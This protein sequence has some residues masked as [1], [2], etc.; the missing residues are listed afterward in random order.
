MPMF[1]KFRVSGTDIDFERL[2]AAF[3]DEPSEI[4]TRGELFYDKFL[5]QTAARPEDVFL[6]ARDY[7]DG[8]AFDDGVMDF[9]SRLLPQKE[10]IRALEQRHRVMLWFSLYPDGYRTNIMLSP[11]TLSLV[12]KLSAQLHIEVSFLQDIYDGKAD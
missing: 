10:L 2:S 7:P 4:L 8:T 3:P 9:C 1:A 5:K 6:I 12:A 11:D